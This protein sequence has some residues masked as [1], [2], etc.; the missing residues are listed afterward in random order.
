[1]CTPPLNILFVGDA[2][3]EEFRLVW[4]RL[5]ARFQACAAVK[6]G[7]QEVL[8]E[9]GSFADDA[10]APG[11]ILLFQSFPGEFLSAEVERL[12]RRFPLAPVAVIYGSWCEGE[13][14]SGK[15]VADAARFHWAE[16]VTAG[17]RALDALSRGEL[18]VFSLPVTLSPEERFL[19]RRELEKKRNAGQESGFLQDAAADFCREKREPLSVF[20]FSPEV[21]QAEMLACVLRADETLRHAVKCTHFADFH[22]GS[23]TPPDFVLADFPEFT[24]GAREAFRALKK[25]YPRAVFFVFCEFIR[26]TQW[27]WLERQGVHHIFRKPFILSDFRVCFCEELREKLIHIPH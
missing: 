6:A 21:E 11:V 2:G 14:R 24:D 9:D 26:V 16:W 19:W 27:R 12:R 10:D 22:A 25:R 7:I 15:P 17:P 3:R 23:V 18:S 20:V 4:E 1:M 5:P 13:T 8:A